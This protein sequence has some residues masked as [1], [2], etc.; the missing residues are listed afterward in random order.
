MSSGLDAV[1]DFEFAKDVSNVVL[2]GSFR[3]EEFLRDL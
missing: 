3:D 2:G 1:V